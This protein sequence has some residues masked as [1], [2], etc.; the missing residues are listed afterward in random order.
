MGIGALAIVSGGVVIAAGAAT[1]ATTAAG[2][3]AAA[4]AAGASASAAG[5]AATASATALSVTV[6]G[7]TAATANFVGAALPLLLSNPIG[8]ITIGY[9]ES[10]EET[11]ME[12]VTVG[13]L[14][15]FKA[16]IHD[17][18]KTPSKTGMRLRDLVQDSRVKSV[19]VSVDDHPDYPNIEMTNEWN[20]T[21]V[22]QY[23]YLEN[24]ELAGHAKLTNEE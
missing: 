5:A 15:C 16:V 9:N 8:W 17:T 22:I 14:D 4:A 7:S 19:K 3:T 6:G 23:V 20:E 24:G 1:A 13:K 18:S 21:F 2:A 12:G 11:E 10:Q